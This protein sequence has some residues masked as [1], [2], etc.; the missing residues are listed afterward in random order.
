MR[1]VP[2][3]CTTRHPS[4]AAS[5]RI[6]KRIKEVFGWTKSTGSLRKTRHNGTD[7]VCRV[8]TL[9]ATAYEAL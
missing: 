1:P 8:F 3:R 7:R 5:L 2:D 4:Y 6:R 9:T